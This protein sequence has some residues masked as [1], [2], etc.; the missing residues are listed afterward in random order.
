MKYLCSIIDGWNFLNGVT[1]CGIG[2]VVS[3]Y[4][5]ICHRF[6]DSRNER[7]Q[8]E[9]LSLKIMNGRFIRGTRVEIFACQHTSKGVIR[10]LHTYGV[11]FPLNGDGRQLIQGVR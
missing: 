4:T 1:L 3:F 6:D 7:A 5:S 8:E 9:V 11:Y 2:G 10:N